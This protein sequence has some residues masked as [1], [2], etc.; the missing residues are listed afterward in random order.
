MLSNKSGEA[1]Q[2]AVALHDGSLQLGKRPAATRKRSMP[3]VSSS[4][5]MEV[6]IPTLSRRWSSESARR[7]TQ[8]PPPLATI[9]AVY[10]EADI[11]LEN[12]R[13]FDV[14]TE[15]SKVV[16]PRAGPLGEKKDSA[17]A[18]AGTSRKPLATNAILHNGC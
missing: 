8:D 11:H 4:L 5:P 16:P 9:P 15:Q 2:F 6:D 1:D 12:P 3:S 10:S 17:N 18:S 14:V 7:A 13:T